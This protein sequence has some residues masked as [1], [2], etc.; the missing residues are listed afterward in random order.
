MLIKKGYKISKN[1]FLFILCFLFI[2][3]SSLTVSGQGLKP[4]VIV[5]G[6]ASL[7]SRGYVSM[8]AFSSTLN[9][10]TDLKNSSIST[11][12][13]AENLALIDQGEIQIGQ[14]MRLDLYNA[15]RG[16]EPYDHKIDFVQ[17]FSYS[18][19]GMT[20]GVLPDSGIETI[21]DLAGKRLAV[22]PASGGAVPIIKAILKEYGI[23]DDV[24]LAYMGWSEAPDALNAGQVDASGIW[25]S[26]ESIPHTGF[27]KLAM[28]REFKLLDM[29]RDKLENIA[30]GNEG[31]SVGK[32]EKEAFYFLTEDKLCAGSSSILVADPNL[33]EE[34][35]YEIVKT[36]F[37]NEE[38][39][40]SIDPQSLGEFYLERALD[41][42]IADYPF[43]PGAVRYFKEV[44]IWSD[45]LL[46]YKYE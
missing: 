9:K 24:S 17:V 11:G 46:V 35:V 20:I 39:V 15:Y 44:G 10:L 4:D 16:I 19:A 34:I 28:I 7:G 30:K 18:V 25:I 2:I 29:D 33:D 26:G 21:K 22:G 5:W 23:L 43:H 13:G 1:Y 38:D 45:D 40:R 31:F 41:N 32:V 42:I 3:I 12:G 14:G 37:E 27:Q 36:L 8:E 6:S